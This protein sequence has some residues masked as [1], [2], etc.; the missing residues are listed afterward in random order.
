MTPPLD[1]LGG[2]P[3]ILAQLTA[4]HDLTA[5][6]T[7]AVL[8]AV[9]DGEASDA[10][11]AAFIV[12]LRQKG[13]TVDELA[14]LVRAMQAAATPLTMPA[15][16]IDIVGM[17]GAAV[18]RRAALNV[19]TMAS[20]VAA[21]A[22][23]IVCK[24]GNRKASSTSGSF[25]LLEAIGVRF[26]LDARELEACVAETGLG[27]AFARVFHPAMRHVGRVRMELGIPTVFN[28]LGPLSHPAGLTHQVIGVA[29]EVLADKMAAVLR[30][31]G[32]IHALVVTGHG[33][34]DELSTTGPSRIRELCGDS[35]V[36]SD[37]DPIDLGIRVPSEGD[38]D[39]GDAAANKAIMERIFSGERSAA[40]DIVAL[41]AAA[42]LVVADV[43]VDLADG[44]ARSVEAMESGAAA[45]KVRDLVEF[46]NGL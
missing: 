4:N 27:F 15:D 25:D 43:A 1:D 38:L 7:E 10:Q 12:G 22:G 45:S 18:R 11:I 42:G 39:G 35:I 3:G 21:A 33:P 14:G 40:R 29:D 36:V 2:W 5:E 6:Q 34:L 8:E 24:H 31:T 37:L 13:E 16:A 41:N 28:A 26:E 23:A 32:S 20:F 44:L 30:S 17:G 9:L 19:S 46:T